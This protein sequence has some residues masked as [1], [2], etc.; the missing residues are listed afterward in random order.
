MIFKGRFFN[1]PIKPYHFIISVLLLLILNCLALKSNAQC[2]AVINTNL[3]PVEGCDPLTIQLF[4]QSSG[5]TV[6]RVWNFGDGTSTSGAQNP[7]HTFNTAGRD[8][9]Y[10]V[11][12][13]TFCLNGDS[14]TTTLSVKVFAKP[15]VDFKVDTTLFCALTDTVCFTNFSDQGAGFTYL[16]NFGDNTSSTILEPCKLYTTDGTYKV[17]L[18]VTDDYGCQ[19]TESK[20]NYVSAQRAPNPDFSLATFSGC[21]P[22]NASISNNT[23]TTSDSIAIWNWNF[24]DNSPVISIKDPLNHNY[25]NPGTY[26]I[27]LQATNNLGCS[28]TT[29]R[30]LIVKESPTASFLFP[31]DACKGDSITIS[32]TGTSNT[33]A[34][35]SWNFSG[36][37][38]ISGSNQGPYVISYPNTGN[39][40]ISSSVSLA[41]CSDSVI[42][43]IQ[44]NQLP[45]G[46]LTNNVNDS[47][48]FG[49]TI[50]FTAQPANYTNYQFQ[51]N[52]NQV[53]SGISNAYSTNTLNT[54]QVVSVAFTDLNGCSNTTTSNN[55]IVIK[56]NPQVEL[57]SLN[58]DSICQG[59]TAY[60]KAIPDTLNSYTFL[61][62]FSPIQNG[63]SDT[64]VIPNIQTNLNINVTGTYKGCQSNTDSSSS[65]TLIKKIAAPVVNCGITTD[66]SITFMW[67]DVLGAEGYEVSVNGQSFIIPSSGPNGLE[68]YISGLTSGDTVKLEVLPKGTGRCGNGILS[69][70]ATCIAQPCDLI[71]F[72]L[73]TTATKICEGESINASLSNITPTSFQSNWMNTNYGTTLTYSFNPTTDTTLIVSVKNSLQINCPAVVKNIPLEVIQTPQITL[74][75]DKDSVCSGTTINFTANPTTYNQYL[76][77]NGF[78][79]LQ[80]SPSPFLTTV[81]TNPINTIRVIGNTNGCSDTASVIS[82]IKVIPPISTPQVTCGTTTNNS[83][84][85]NWDS[86]SNSTGYLISINGGA[87]TTPSS[88]NLG[89]TH[90]VNGLNPNTGL[91]I[92]V[93][94]SGTNPCGNSDYSFSQTCYAKPCT[95]INFIKSNDITVCEGDSVS[96]NISGITIPN[97]SVVWDGNLPGNN[98]DY[99]F[100]ADT[101]VLIEVSVKNNIETSCP[102]AKKYINVN[103]I[104]TPVVYISTSNDSSCLGSY[105]TFTASP[106]SYD[107][108]TFFNNFQLVQNSSN[109]YYTTNNL[110]NNQNIK[111]ISTKGACKDTSNLLDITVV[112]PL[113]V[114]LP[115]CSTST[116][117][118]IYF[119]WDSVYNA[120]GYEISLNGGPFSAPSSGSNGTYHLVSG[121]N[122]NDSIKLVVRALGIPPCGNS[123]VSSEATCVARNCTGINFNL[124]IDSLVCENTSINAAISNLNISNYQTNW[125][126]S[127]N[128][129]QLTFTTNASNSTTINVTVTNTSEPN[130]PS[131]SKSDF[132]IVQPVINAS[133]TSTA[134]SVNLCEGTTVNVTASPQNISNYLFYLN[135]NLI[136]SGNSPY[137]NNVPLVFGSNQLVVIPKE[138]S[139]NGIGDT[140]NL[141]YFQTP[142]LNFNFSG[143]PD[144]ICEGSSIT[145]NVIP[146]NLSNYMFNYNDSVVQ[147]GTSSSLTFIPTNSNPNLLTIIAENSGGCS[148]NTDSVKFKV[149]AL[150]VVSLTRNTSD[151]ICR[152]QN[153]TL[154]ANPPSIGTYNFYLNNTLVQTGSS[155]IYSSN[156]FDTG[157][158]IKLIAINNFK[159]PSVVSSAFG[160]TIKPTYKP[161]INVDDSIAICLGSTYILTSVVNPPI[162][163]LTYSWSNGATTPSITV[164]PST[165]TTYLAFTNL[166][167][168]SSIADTV[169]IAVDDQPLPIA[170]AGI[171]STIC[172]GD[173]IELTGTGGQ[174]YFWYHENGDLIGSGKTVYVKLLKEETFQLVAF[175][176]AC[177]DEDT[178]RIL[179]DKCLKDITG[180]IPQ[181]I[182]P[183]ND[184]ANDSWII[185]DIDY[186]KQNKVVIY[187]R[188]GNVV[189]EASPYLNNWQGV[190]EKGAELPDGTYYYV[191]NINN[192]ENK[193]YNGFVVIHR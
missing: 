157:D 166:N 186:F 99:S 85:F 67:D 17:E 22:F 90:T 108:Y 173:S 3:N 123:A 152:N 52:G 10:I 102:V 178:V 145:V 25:P 35:Y 83:I 47:A 154:N 41:G 60:F 14:S 92:V 171:G 16:W 146:S 34:V 56:P 120:N 45:I 161:T 106:L 59:D 151:S 93:Q 7:I 21:A 82:N 31:N 40:S 107:N 156:S 184:G 65:V 189:W 69:N 66:T 147:N 96:L 125:Q 168:C 153:V 94:S 57:I 36:A 27:T 177:S 103:V 148:N 180:P 49:S 24:G 4:D 109:P 130:C 126:N 139:C 160:F 75:A 183:N 193:I 73:S 55:P 164:S 133:I 150:P 64:L 132:V 38:V 165:N 13:K 1:M 76:F 110:L 42:Q 141:N 162:S 140:L 8:T 51:V 187:N 100:I 182:S 192:T 89:L 129:N 111:V 176:L 172:K 167:S 86:I 71:N 2:T 127:G 105:V 113:M 116:T 48:C 138:N 61:N 29:T 88:G 143:P 81:L 84:T 98:L 175:N 112:S 169:V 70:Q 174:S 20:I 95:A 181:I 30:P 163:G 9:T 37:L 15:K 191:V 118:L 26:I 188:W 104:N 170:D 159:C 131:V 122:A 79:L 32:F 28:N 11:K 155:N 149:I 136:Q 97:Y 137:W 72:Q 121:L 6:N 128:G 91:T 119:N 5:F 80:N 63:S 142:V 43:S 19:N 124:S 68:H 54:G 62:G 158:S 115:N 114:P 53:Q 44:I 179:V 39:F 101:S 117:N 46:F 50:I 74:S 33:N 190:N 78:V 144:T 134:N 23:N 135:N 87:F 185:P 58:G 18:T 12:L 77:Y